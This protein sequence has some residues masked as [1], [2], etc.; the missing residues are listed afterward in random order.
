M[1]FVLLLLVSRS[2]I[3]RTL[4][5]GYFMKNALVSLYFLSATFQFLKSF[6]LK[7]NDVFFS[8]LFVYVI[9][10]MNKFQFPNIFSDRPL[11]S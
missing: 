6:M 1:F 10:A 3:K 8:R 4:P 5:A 2:V 9:M 11:C 7:W